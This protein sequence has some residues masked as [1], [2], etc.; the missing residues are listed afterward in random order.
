[1]S[2]GLVPCPTTVFTFGLFMLADR[3]MPRYFLAIPILFTIGAV[4]PVSRGILEDIGLIVAGVVATLM[5]LFRDSKRQ[6]FTA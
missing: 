1:M 3:R 4:V 5:I 2:F 6:M